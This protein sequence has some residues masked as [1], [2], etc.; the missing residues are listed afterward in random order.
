MAGLV[1][2]LPVVLEDREG[3]LEL[4]AGPFACCLAEM[5]GEA[6]PF[7]VEGL[8]AKGGGLPFLTRPRRRF[9]NKRVEEVNRFSMQWE[10]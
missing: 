5:D 3:R 7:G 6:Q 10:W 8:A 2:Q 9:L 4:H 1:A